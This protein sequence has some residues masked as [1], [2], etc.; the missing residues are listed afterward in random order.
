MPEKALYL[1][2]EESRYPPRCYT[3]YE[4]HFNPAQT[5]S[6]MVVG[7]HS[8]WSYVTRLGSWTEADQAYGYK[9]TRPFYE[10]CCVVM[11]IVVRSF[12]CISYVD[13]F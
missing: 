12:T 6:R 2:A 1:S 9:D 10:V 5:L 11:K 4:P 7:T 13:K 3:N 8:G